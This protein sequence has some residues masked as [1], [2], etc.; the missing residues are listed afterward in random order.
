MKILSWK[1]EVNIQS[2]LLKIICCLLLFFFGS[3]LHSKQK[4]ALSEEGQI[5]VLLRELT[6]VEQ[7]NY[8]LGDIARLEGANPYIIE[9]L[10]KVRIGRS[11]LP[12]RH[13]TV[14]RSIILSRLRS[15][16][17]E[18]KGLVFP[19]SQSTR[20]QRAALKI[21]GTDID[22]TVLEH[23][24]ESNPD[25]DIKP[26]ILAKS[27]DIYL[28]RGQV[29][30]RILKKGRHLKEGGYRTFEVEFSVDGKVLRKLP[31]RTYVK[32]YKEVV[33]AKDTIKRDQVI[34]ETDLMKV[35]RNVDRMSNSYVTEENEII[36][37]VSSRAINPNEVIRGNTLSKASI[38]SAGD[39]LL[40]VFET[41]NLKLSAP[42]V[43]LQKGAFGERI[44]VRNLESKIMVYATVKDRN[45]VR[46][47]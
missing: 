40:I 22:R 16:N 47:N 14:T 27:R 9:N 15:K 30:Y 7:E 31:V 36:G 6:V 44:Q 26:R 42:G 18:T 33:I 35:R 43:S 45:H 37:K 32:L 10:E 11:P 8:H 19:G 46:V 13:I 39:R 23:I 17:F 5:R 25:S 41:P 3:P 21:T 28:P 24:R 29:S 12:G 38:I 34:T 4:Y 1:T 2:G 20:I